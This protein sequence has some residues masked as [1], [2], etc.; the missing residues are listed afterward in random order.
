MSN[1]YSRSI[2]LVIMSLMFVS[3]CKKS[4]DDIY[5]SA[6]DIRAKNTYQFRGISEGVTINQQGYRIKCLLNDEIIELISDLNDLRASLDYCEDNFIGLKKDIV[7]LSISCDQDI[8][9]TTA[10]TPLDN[11]N[12]R[13]YENKFP[14]DSQ[15]KRLTIQEW[16]DFVNNEDQLITF[17]W[18]I[19][20]NEPIVSTEYLKFKLFFELADGSEYSTETEL[21]KI[22]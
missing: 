1:K 6:N 7:N 12:I 19:E 9:N 5:F 20:F 13:I 22:E 14:E 2:L 16:L 10:G 8:W 3:C 4:F 18:F 15:N 17:E 21:V 11:M